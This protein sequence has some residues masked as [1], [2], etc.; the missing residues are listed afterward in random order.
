MRYAIQLTLRSGFREKKCLQLCTVRSVIIACP[1]NRLVHRLIGF[2]EA[3]NE[4]EKKKPPATVCADGPKTKW[5]FQWKI[6]GVAC[7][8]RQPHINILSVK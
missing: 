4:I 7:N 8:S 2:V 1:S 3:E 5:K 6:K